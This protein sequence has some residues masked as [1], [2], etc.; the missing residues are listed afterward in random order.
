MISSSGR[1]DRTGCALTE[2]VHEK[3]EQ[4]EQQVQ[5]QQVQHQ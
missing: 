5:H 3:R 2:R 1:E 4:Q